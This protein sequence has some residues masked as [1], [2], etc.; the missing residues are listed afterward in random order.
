[1]D[2]GGFSEF[3]DH[4]FFSASIRWSQK[5]VQMLFL[6]IKN[7]F[8][9]VHQTELCPRAWHPSRI[10]IFAGEVSKNPTKSW[11]PIGFSYKWTWKENIV[12]GPRFFF[13]RHPDTLKCC[14]L[15]SFRKILLKRSGSPDRTIWECFI[16][17][18]NASGLDDTELWDPI[19]RGQMAHTPD[20]SFFIIWMVTRT[21]CIFH[22]AETLPHCS[23]WWTAAFL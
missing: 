4:R 21:H 1:M 12:R 6:S 5:V 10:S 16:I 2:F 15:F 8:L 17:V 3:W 11:S 18:K 7:I 14:F 22:E 23:V 9:A 19:S 13:S 20:W